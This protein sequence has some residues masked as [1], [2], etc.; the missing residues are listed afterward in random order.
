MAF[1]LLKIIG[2]I[3]LAIVLIP[4]VWR[5]SVL[6]VTIGVFL[7]LCVAVLYAIGVIAG[8]IQTMLQENK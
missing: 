6:I 7:V 8:A 2:C 5:I 3:L 1:K 4:I